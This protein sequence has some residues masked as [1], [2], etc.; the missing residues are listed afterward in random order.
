MNKSKEKSA[1]GAR[2][3]GD[4]PEAMSKEEAKRICSNMNEIRVLIDKAHMTRKCDIC[5]TRGREDVEI[6][7]SRDDEDLCKGCR[8]RLTGREQANCCME[9][10]AYEK[11][12]HGEKCK[13]CWASS[14]KKKTL[15]K[16]DSRTCER[17]KG[18]M[19]KHTKKKKF[20]GHPICNKCSKS[21]PSP[22]R[23]YA[24]MLT[25]T[26]ELEEEEIIADMKQTYEY[27]REQ[28]RLN[29]GLDNSAE[30]IYKKTTK[31]A[32]CTLTEE[33]KKILE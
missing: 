17:C 23:A 33:A 14:L 6:T 31:E 5:R 19:K 30:W 15:D 21:I 16:R 32:N 9:C 11:E 3:V 27:G 18:E 10:G 20:F 12:M 24:A 4:I 25:E 8:Q 26:E 28:N 1:S 7:P 22:L 13:Y 29:I 2:T